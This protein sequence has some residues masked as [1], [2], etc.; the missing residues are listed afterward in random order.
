MSASFSEEHKNAIREVVE[1][2]LREEINILDRGYKPLEE[3]PRYRFDYRPEINSKIENLQP[4]FD[5]VIQALERGEKVLWVTNSVQSCI[6]IYRKSKEY[7]DKLNN[8]QINL[9][10]YHSRF[11]Y[12]ERAGYKDQLGIKHPGK[13]DQVIVAFDQ[14]NKNPCLAITTQV[15]EMSLDLSADLLVSPMAPAAALIQRLGRLNRQVEEY[16]PEKFRVEKI[17]TAIFYAWDGSPYTNEE[18]RTGIQLVESLHD[19][20]SV[21]QEN[22]ADIAAQ[23]TLSIPTEE[24]NS[25]WLDGDLETYSEPLRE[26]GGTIT[27]LLKQ[28]E[29]AI[30]EAAYTNNKSFMKEAQG[31]SVPIRFLPIYLQWDKR[32]Y[33]LIAPADEITYDPEVGAEPCKH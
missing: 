31:W 4:I 17:H 5:V 13:H 10:I 23:I 30:K 11:R 14:K 21:S 15:C 3:I 2:D 25:M 1:N 27:V 9:L 12:R 33:Y 29:T 28:D 24:T 20:E 19:R 8:P 6:D 18:M 22:L 26:G 16:A 7:I 32:K